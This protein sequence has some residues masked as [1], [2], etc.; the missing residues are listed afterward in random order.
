MKC[1]EVA[2]IILIIS[3]LIVLFGVHKAAHEVSEKIT[4]QPVTTISE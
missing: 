2:S 1:R 3:S 4:G